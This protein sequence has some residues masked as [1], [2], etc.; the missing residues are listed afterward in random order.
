MNMLVKMSDQN[1]IKDLMN[2]FKEID[3]D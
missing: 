2:Q 3:K 1:D